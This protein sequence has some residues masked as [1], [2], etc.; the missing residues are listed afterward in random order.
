LAKDNY[1]LGEFNL[2]GIE[3]APAGVPELNVTFEI[4]TNGIL[5]VSAMDKKTLSKNN[6][7]ITKT[8][9]HLSEDEIRRMIQTAKKLEVEDKI[10]LDLLKAKNELETFI[11]NQMNSTG[12]K[13]NQ[14]IKEM[15]ESLSWLKNDKLTKHE[16]YARLN[17]LSVK[18]EQ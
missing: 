7:V 9:G 8:K 15:N 16:I 12:C 14:Y 18:K 11:Y 1:L 2:D 10:K 3:D 17:K 6:T 5:H 4:D 13:S